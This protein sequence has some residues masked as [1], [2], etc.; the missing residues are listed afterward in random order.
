MKVSIHLNGEK[1]GESTYTSPTTVG[2]Q[3]EHP[4][5]EGTTVELKIGSHE[6]RLE[7]LAYLRSGDKGDTANIGWM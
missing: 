1:M 6:Y 2:G 7:Q 3:E 5:A 4:T